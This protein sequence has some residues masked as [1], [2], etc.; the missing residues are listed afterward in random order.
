MATSTVYSCGF[1]PVLYAQVKD[2]FRI[3]DAAASKAEEAASRYETHT[4][5][6]LQANNASVRKDIGETS[7]LGANCYLPPNA[8]PIAEDTPESYEA[9][10]QHDNIED[11][12][13][14]NDDGPRSFIHQISSHSVPEA[15]SNLKCDIETSQNDGLPP[16][17][18]AKMLRKSE[19]LPDH[20]VTDFQTEKNSTLVSSARMSKS[21][22]SASQS[23]PDP[24]DQSSSITTDADR[25]RKRPGSTPLTSKVLDQRE[26][27]KLPKP[28]V[29]WMNGGGRTA[30][31]S[32]IAQSR[33]EI[34]EPPRIKKPPRP[35]SSSSQTSSALKNTQGAFGTAPQTSNIRT[36][37]TP[38]SD[39]VEATSSSEKKSSVPKIDRSATENLPLHLANDLA[40]TQ[41]FKDTIYTYIKSSE[42]EYRGR[43]PDDILRTIG[44][45][46][47]DHKTTPESAK[48]IRKA[49][50]EIGCK[51]NSHPK[52]SKSGEGILIRFR[53]RAK[54]D[55]PEYGQILVQRKSCRFYCAYKF[56]QQK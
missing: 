44:K 5:G 38:N 23:S 4:T 50:I 28:V 27:H 1:S 42:N 39:A 15:C 31:G 25:A 26:Q 13:A 18:N 55:D 35:R 3:L 24:L 34:Q 56:S 40:F 16:S 17:L 32:T 19:S 10:V 52:P 6:L 9:R 2:E 12:F 11:K 46:V 7:D 51:P 43:V 37:P 21:R 30:S 20:K 54:E 29:E 22:S 53:E 48:S 49:D 8:P 45:S 36:K 41:V 47:S 33:C 14:A